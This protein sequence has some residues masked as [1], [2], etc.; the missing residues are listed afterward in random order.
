MTKQRPGMTREINKD[1]DPD[2]YDDNN[3][4]EYNENEGTGKVRD[5]R[6]KMTTITLEETTIM[7][8]IR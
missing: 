5:Q 1:G 7:I 3:D 4:S 8:L 6:I 2:N